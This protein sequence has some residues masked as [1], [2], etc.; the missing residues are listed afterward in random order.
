MSTKAVEIIVDHIKNSSPIKV[1][2]FQ[3][4]KQQVLRIL[5]HSLSSSMSNR[6]RIVVNH[7]PTVV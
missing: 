4:S 7:I 1:F 6:C 2:F 5:S 3:V